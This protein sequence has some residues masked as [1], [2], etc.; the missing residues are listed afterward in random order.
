M[1]VAPRLQ[2]F[3]W[4]ARSA[5]RATDR[6]FGVLAFS[7]LYFRQDASGSRRG[8]LAAQKCRGKRAG[9]HQ[10]LLLL[11][12]PTCSPAYH[13]AACSPPSGCVVQHA[14]KV[15]PEGDIPPKPARLGPEA[16]FHERRAV[17]ERGVVSYPDFK[18][19]F[20]APPHPDKIVAKAEPRGH[21]PTPCACAGG[22]P[23]RG[24]VA[25]PPRW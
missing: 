11:F 16:R 25:R 21:P 14:S 18:D 22:C 6:P 5:R 20:R 4:S 8:G 15:A 9:T 19:P 3:F 24:E 10:E 1:A 12:R 23:P 7:R 2:F 13:P 17:R